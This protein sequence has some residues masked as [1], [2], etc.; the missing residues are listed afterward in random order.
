MPPCPP[1]GNV[2]LIPAPAPAARLDHADG[3]GGE[4][5]VDE[6]DAHAGND[7]AGQ[8][9]GP[10]VRGVDPGHEQESHADQEQARAEERPHG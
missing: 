4:R 6:S 7:E 5:R 3:R 10:V 2:L 8:Q 1:G 9:D